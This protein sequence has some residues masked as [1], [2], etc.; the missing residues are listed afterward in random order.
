MRAPLARARLADAAGESALLVLACHVD[1]RRRGVH[2]LV[3]AAARRV[4][5]G[6]VVVLVR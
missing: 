1:A 4:V 2:F 5:V 3:A 6:V